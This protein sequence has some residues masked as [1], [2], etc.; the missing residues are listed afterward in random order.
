MLIEMNTYYKAQLWALSL[1]YLK[2]SKAFLKNMEKKEDMGGH[3]EIVKG[4]A[5]T[6]S[7]PQ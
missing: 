6:V 3:T 7:K 1:S 5:V 2:H 4:S